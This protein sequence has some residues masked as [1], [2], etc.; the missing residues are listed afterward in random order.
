MNPVNDLSSYFF[1]I[2]FNVIIT[3]TSESLQ[4]VSFFKIFLR[5]I[6]ADNRFRTELGSS[7]WRL[8]KHARA[9]YS[10]TERS[11]TR[12]PWAGPGRSAAHNYITSMLASKEESF[13]RLRGSST[14]SLNRAANARGSK[15]STR[16]AILRGVQ[17]LWRAFP[18][19]LSRRC[20]LQRLR[21]YLK[22]L[23]VSVFR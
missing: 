13:P 21:V 15:H 12:S 10:A 8:A 18:P 9:G 19:S 16:L 2:Y 22:T 14:A 5:K 1:K 17:S 4:V 7:E 3:P 23:D 20:I 11:P 6:S